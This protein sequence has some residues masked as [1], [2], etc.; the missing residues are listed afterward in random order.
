MGNGGNKTVTKF[1]NASAN[2]TGHK[3]SS[4]KP[5]LFQL[6]E[7][8]EF[9]KVLSLIAIFE[10]LDICNKDHVVLHFDTVNDG[11]PRNLC[12]IFEYHFDIHEKVTHNYQEFA[13]PN[14]SILVCSYLTFRGLE[15]PEIT[16]IVDRDIYFLQHYLVESLA[17]CTSKLTVV[18]LQNSTTLTKV[19][20][21]WK[22]I[23]WSI[24]GKSF[25]ARIHKEHLDIKKQKNGKI[26]VTFESEHY[27]KMEERFNSLPNNEDETKESK[28]KSLAKNLIAQNR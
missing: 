10:N 21:E 3:I 25:V 11:I 27:E 28:M 13:L 15:H 12:F 2:E 23:S 14:R 7:R 19:L 24:N 16:I 20:E 22:K 1:T 9:Q 5:A 8:S 4:E 6:E 17:R 26:E 18:V